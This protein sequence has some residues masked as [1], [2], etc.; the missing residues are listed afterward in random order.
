[1]D[2]DII[3][4][5][6]EFNARQKSTGGE[7][8]SVSKI[9]ERHA[10]VELDCDSVDISINY[11]RDKDSVWFVTEPEWLAEALN[12]NILSGKLATLPS[13]LG[14]LTAAVARHN[15]QSDLVSSDASN[16]SDLAQSGGL[17]V[18]GFYE[19]DDGGRHFALGPQQYADLKR[20]VEEA[21][22]ML[23]EDRVQLV[24]ELGAVKMTLNM[25]TMLDATLAQKLGFYPEEPVF[26]SFSYEKGPVPS[27]TFT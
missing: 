9:D 23:G 10:H 15:E 20:H 14:A 11:P 22:E 27:G 18:S 24:E 1:M 8:V 6:Q 19:D 3:R 12:V 25:Y 26:V 16:A 21:K 5:I 13:I 7:K 4:T 17:G 2:K